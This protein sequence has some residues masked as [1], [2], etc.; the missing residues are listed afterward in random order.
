MWDYEYL[1]NDDEGYHLNFRTEETSFQARPDDTYLFLFP[2]W[3]D[4]SFIYRITE[5]T[6][7]G[8]RGY[9]IFERM[10]NERLGEGVWSKLIDEMVEVDFDIAEQEEPDADDIDSY[11]KMFGEA[12]RKK[13]SLEAI[14]RTAMDHFED[15]WK[16]YSQEPGWGDGEIS[17]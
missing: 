15:E 11:C 14:V 2:E 3:E 5:L 1:S 17:Q 13:H 8:Y 10:I 7:T 12:P 6:E 9:R 4:C 16:Y